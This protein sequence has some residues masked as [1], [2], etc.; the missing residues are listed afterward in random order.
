MDFLYFSFPVL[1]PSVRVVE[2]SPCPIHR[3]SSPVLHSSPCVPPDFWFVSRK[4]S[5]IFRNWALG[6]L[7][8][9][10]VT[11]F[12]VFFFF[13]PPKAYPDRPGFPFLHRP[14]TL[15]SFPPVLVLLTPITGSLFFLVIDEVGGLVPHLMVRFCVPPMSV[16]WKRPGFFFS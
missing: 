12:L 1:S 6:P 8:G 5:L 10:C 13:G 15:P 14:T 11:F 2:L 9:F 3:F 16:F 7:C 4:W